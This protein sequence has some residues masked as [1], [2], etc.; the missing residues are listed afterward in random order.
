MIC[1][2][3]ENEEFARTE[4]AVIEQELKGE[5]FQVHT[6]ALACSKC[7]WIALDA[8]TTEELRRRTADAY[9]KKHGLLTSEEIRALRKLLHKNQSQFANLVGV[10]EASVKRW[11]TWLVQERSSD[12]LI[13]LTCEKALRE[14]LPQKPP[15]NVWISFDISFTEVTNGFTV[16]NEPAKTAMPSR[17]ALTPDLPEGMA[18]F[19]GSFW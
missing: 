1:L 9:R 2:R 7:G 19:A 11:E 14:L 10:G 4:D 6:P 12:Q 5:V 3:C 17:C 16:Q 18:V 15:A 13:R 8:E